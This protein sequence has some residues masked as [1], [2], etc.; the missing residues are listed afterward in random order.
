SSCEASVF[1]LWPL[2]VTVVVMGCSPIEF[3][4]CS[5][6]AH[7]P[8][9]ERCAFGPRLLVLHLL[10][11]TRPTAMLG[12]SGSR[13][14]LGQTGRFPTHAMKIRSF[15]RRLAHRRRTEPLRSAK[16]S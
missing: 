4:R 3:L 5:D 16:S 2:V 9:M 14:R 7:R 13:A 6:A 12:A 15:R 11:L 10:R 1:R 8:P